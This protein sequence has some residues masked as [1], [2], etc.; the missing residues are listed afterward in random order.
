MK[1]FGRVGLVFMALAVMLQF[2]PAANGKAFAY[3]IAFDDHQNLWLSDFSGT[4]YKLDPT[5]KDGMVVESFTYPLTQSRNQSVSWR[6]LAWGGGYLWAS[7]WTNDSSSD[8]IYKINPE[9]GTIVAS[10]NVPLASSANGIAWDG[11]KLWVGD[12]N[13][14]IY[15][16]NP[17][18][19]KIIKSVSIPENSGPAN[20]RGLAWDGQ[21][22][23]AGYQGDGVI[24]KHKKNGQ[25][26][27]SFDSPLGWTQQGL[28]YYN[29]HLWAAGSN[30]ED[31]IFGPPVICEIDP[32][33]GAEISHLAPF[34][35]QDP[36][37]PNDPTAPV[38]EPATII[39]LGAGLL[40]LAGAS[41]KKFKKP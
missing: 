11:N 5:A 17:K 16:I 9:D 24:K 39:L 14:K 12:E 30:E 21:N 40:G 34:T 7:N 15:K 19:G 13:Y 10:F 26:I 32:L 4:I 3:G 23:W 38:P 25:V 37:D 6:D 20:P 31:G 33:T 8:E 22:I 41:R 36:T 2:L 1:R 18:N 27:A 35:P 28:D 29:G